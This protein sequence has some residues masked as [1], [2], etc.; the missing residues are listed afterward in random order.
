M[1]KMP[2]IPGW[3]WLIVIL[4]LGL[5]LRLAGIWRTEPI[6]YHPDEWVV[7][8]PVM[9]LANE[10]QV[11][12]KNHYKW[13]AC[14]VIYIL[15]Y[16][17]Y[18]LKGWFGPYSYNSILIIQRVISGLAGTA[19][20]FL[21]FLLMRKIFSEQTAI[22]SAA[23][24]SVAK[25]P[26]L[27]GHYG[28]ITSIVSLVILAVMLLSCD[29][30]DVEPG[31]KCAL[32]TGRCCLLGLIYGLGVAAKWT[33]LFAVIPVSGA[34]LLSVWYNRKLH[35]WGEFIKINIQRICLIAGIGVLSFLAGL[36]DVYFNPEKVFSG[37]KYE[38]EHHQTGHYGALTAEEKQLSYRIP[39]RIETMKDAGSVYLFIPGL[40]AIVYCLV[41]PSRWR[42]FL[43]WTI[44]IWLAMLCKN[45]LAGE[46]HHL[47]PFILMILILSVG[48]EAMVCSHRKYLRFGGFALFLFLFVM[49]LIYCC[50][51]IS[52]FWRPDARVEC[53]N[54]IK[55]NVPSGSGVAWAPRTPVWGAPGGVVEPSLFEVYPRNAETGKEQYIIAA[56]S[57]LNIFKK[58]PPYKKIV[59]SEWFPSEPPTM[60]ELKLYAEMNKGGGPNLTLVKEFSTK[61]SFLGLDLRLFGL[62]PNEDTTFANR[63]VS[64][65][66]LNTP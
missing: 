4:S 20:V 29:L 51:W 55:A 59:P 19:A 21:S 66:R 53:G 31:R 41:E 64:L 35:R 48:L 10:G 23:L 22:F 40:L 42:I 54:W 15:G 47:V 52:P 37:L 58:H 57:R 1:K 13:P 2:S 46:R 39:K 61:P 65:F 49:E 16:S 17:L 27:Q 34:F 6:D 50:I 12:L 56:R 5:F 9:S 7:A 63:S 60:A 25:A 26:V 38:V 3:I 24:L 28:T 14:S 30:F 62:D 36:P 45:K 33:I 44:S 43:V 11:G 8:R 32:K 18:G